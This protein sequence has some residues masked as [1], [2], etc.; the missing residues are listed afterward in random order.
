MDVAKK[1]QEIFGIE[2]VISEEEA[3]AILEKVLPKERKQKSNYTFSFDEIEDMCVE[4]AYLEYDTGI[5]DARTGVIVQRI[6]QLK[7]LRDMNEIK[8]TASELVNG[9]NSLTK[10]DVSPYIKY[11]E[12]LAKS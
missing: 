11:F 12:K 1:W 6:M 3:I 2:M 7:I 4:L 9:L 10:K 5:V 8:K